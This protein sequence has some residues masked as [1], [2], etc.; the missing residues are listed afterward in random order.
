MGDQS[1]SDGAKAKEQVKEYQWKHPVVG[2]VIRLLIQEVTHPTGSVAWVLAK[3]PVE[4]N[5]HVGVT[6]IHQVAE[7]MRERFRIEPENI[8]LYAAISDERFQR[9]SF[10][11]YGW[12]PNTEQVMKQKPRIWTKG[13]YKKYGIWL[14]WGEAGRS[15]PLTATEVE[16]AIGCKLHSRFTQKLAPAKPAPTL[17]EVFGPQIDREAHKRVQER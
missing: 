12:S 2:A 7:L 17:A 1:A 5:R 16:K 3:A 10:R 8:R 15:N 11:T 6:C 14:E 9:I 4:R 13:Y